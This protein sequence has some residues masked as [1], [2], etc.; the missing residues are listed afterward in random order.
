MNEPLTFGR[1]MKR[2][3]AEQ[4]LTQER[5]AEQIGCAAQTIRS[6]ESGIR[7]PSRELAARLADALHVPPEQRTDFLR[8]ARAT[9]E[10][11]SASLYDHTADAPPQPRSNQRRALPVP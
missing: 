5:L 11:S 1:W 3:R 2:L 8:L 6:F 7:R 9:L 4:D 10:P